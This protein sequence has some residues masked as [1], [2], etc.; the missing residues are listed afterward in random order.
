MNQLPLDVASEDRSPLT[1]FS[2]CHIGIKSQLNQ[3]AN[4]S[5]MLNPAIQAHKIAKET[6]QFF[7]RA[8]LDHHKEE[9]KDLFPMV[10]STA[11]EGEEKTKV[12]NMIKLLVKEHREVESMW[13]HL[14]PQLKKFLDN[15][16][17]NID[18][19]SIENLVRTYLTHAK[20]EED[21][22]LPL[23]EL[24]L[25]RNSSEMATL[26]LSIHTRKVLNNARRGL[27]GS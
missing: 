13:R 4:L 9:E 23:S 8:V 11:K 14:E 10:L 27:R 21:E 6:I 17:S 1:N 3:L 26:G 22:F 5:V 18:I 24:I 20:F 16:E 25:S 12:L 7:N 19:P 15:P 2:D